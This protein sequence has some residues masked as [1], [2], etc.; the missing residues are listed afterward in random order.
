MATPNQEK[1]FLSQGKF[2]YPH[3]RKVIEAR[4]RAMRSAAIRE[5]AWAI[6]RA[7]RGWFTRSAAVAHRGAHIATRAA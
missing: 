7:V 1:T 5:A 2:I 4:A 6:G 3:D